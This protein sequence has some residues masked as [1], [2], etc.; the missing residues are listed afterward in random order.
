MGL[1]PRIS[2]NFVAGRVAVWTRR[3]EEEE[4]EEEDDDVGSHAR[5]QGA[6]DNDQG[7]RQGTFCMHLAVRAGV[8]LRRGAVCGGWM[9]SACRALFTPPAPRWGKGIQRAFCRRCGGR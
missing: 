6:E 8:L 7:K 5:R 2:A 3:S 4:D 9:A 1:P